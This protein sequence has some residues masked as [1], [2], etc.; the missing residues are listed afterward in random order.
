MGGTGN[1]GQDPIK[2]Q[3]LSTS[4]DGGGAAG[5]P[6]WANDGSQVPGAGT[7]MSNGVP[8]AST[9]PAVL[10]DYEL[11]AGSTGAGATTAPVQNLGF[12]TAAEPM[13]FTH[14]AYPTAAA[15]VPTYAGA[16]PA[17]PAAAA[18]AAAAEDP[19]ARVAVYLPGGGFGFG[20]ASGMFGNTGQY[21]YQQRAG[22]NGQNQAISNP[23]GISIEGVDSMNDPWQQRE[24]RELGWL[25]P[26]SYEQDTTMQW[27]LGQSGV[28]PTTM[29]YKPGDAVAAGT[30]N[31]PTMSKALYD[32]N[33]KVYGNPYGAG[34]NQQYI[35]GPTPTP[36]V[37]GD[38]Q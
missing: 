14:A 33:M 2:Q 34:Y 16:A 32:W 26:K 13:G 35:G 15:D 4:V 19:N 24:A 6:G 25:D 29:S 10:R 17:A 8:P 5:T 7:P 12:P 37:A 21:T 30:Q 38:H 36:V 3:G 23:Y 18:P 11:T 9:E 1:T 28:K 27:H 22:P 20:T 31:V